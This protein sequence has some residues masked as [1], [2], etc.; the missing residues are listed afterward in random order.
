ML[1]AVDPGGEVIGGVRLH[2]APGAPEA[3]IGWWQGSRLVVAAGASRA[4]PG[5]RGRIGAALVRAACARALDAGALRFDA[6]VQ[7][8]QIGFFTRLGWEPIRTVAVAGT[9]HA[10]MRWPVDRCARLAAATKQPL[11]A[12]VGRLLAGDRWRGDDAVPVPGSD[13]VAC[14]DAITP[15]MVDRDPDWAGWC[16]M[17]VT[18]HD[19]ACDGGVAGGWRSGYHGRQWD[20]TSWRTRAQLAPMLGVVAGA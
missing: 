16:G 8:A 15:S 2:P 12:L 1:V 20:S 9:P 17:L 6:H 3:E 14:T 11:G 18:A 5:A 10:L 4:G 7:E 19:L 13:V